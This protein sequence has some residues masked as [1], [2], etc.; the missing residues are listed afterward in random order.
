MWVCEEG[1]CSCMT[2]YDAFVLHIYL[3]LVSSRMRDF[4]KH[5]AVEKSTSGHRMESVREAF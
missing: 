2:K 3:Q 4:I 1:T 5:E